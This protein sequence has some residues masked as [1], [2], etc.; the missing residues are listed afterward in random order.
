MSIHHH[1]FWYVVRHVCW[2]VVPFPAILHR[3]QLFQD[4]WA[5]DPLQRPTAAE[6]VR[7]LEQML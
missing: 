2:F 4:M 1:V 5:D 6:V 3:H 7:R